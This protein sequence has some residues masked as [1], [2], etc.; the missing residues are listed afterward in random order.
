MLPEE[1]CWRP[2]RSSSSG[3][4]ISVDLIGESSLGVSTINLTAGEGD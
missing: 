1:L 4:E 2:T 3:I